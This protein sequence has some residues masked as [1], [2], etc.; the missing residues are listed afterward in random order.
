H[1]IDNLSSTFSEASNNFNL[2]LLDPFNPGLDKGN[3]DYDI[4]HRFV[5]S[6]VWE[7]PFGKN[8]KGLFRQLAYGYGLSFVFDANTRTPFTIFDCPNAITVCNRLLLVKAQRMTGMENAPASA[9]DAP[10]S[11]KFIDLSAQSAA[12]GAFINPIT[13]NAELGPFPQNMV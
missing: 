2:G 4:R 9:P 12:V 8:T 7:I 5:T 6:G 11:F 3:A 13:G 1:A 10:N